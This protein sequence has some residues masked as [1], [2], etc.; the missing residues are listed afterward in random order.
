MGSLSFCPFAGVLCLAWRLMDFR[1]MLTVLCSRDGPHPP[2]L[3]CFPLSSLS[4]LLC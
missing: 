4:L 1:F 3:H 2:T